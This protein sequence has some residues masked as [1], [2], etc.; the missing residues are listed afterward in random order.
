MHGRLIDC[1][2]VKILSPTLNAPHY[3]KELGLFLFLDALVGEMDGEI[4][5]ECRP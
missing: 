4:E 2:G 3:S 5:G 1:N